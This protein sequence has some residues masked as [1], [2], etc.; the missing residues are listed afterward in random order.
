MKLNV[1]LSWSRSRSY[2]V[3]TALKQFLKEI[4]QGVAPQMSDDIESGGM[5]LPQLNDLLRKA[6][7][8]VLCITSDNWKEPWIYYEVGMVFGKSEE[9]AKVFPYIIDLNMQR[10]NLPEPLKQFTAV[11]AN[12]EGTYKLVLAINKALDYPLSDSKLKADFDANW[13]GLKKVIGDMQPA[14]DQSEPSPGQPGSPSKRPNPRL[15]VE[16][17]GM[18]SECIGS[19]Q[20]RLDSRLR[21]CIDTAIK[22]AQSGA[23]DRDRLID[24]AW[25]EIEESKERFRDKNSI[26]VGNVADFF[27]E[28]YSIDKL[29]GVVDSMEIDLLAGRDP[30]IVAD[31]LVARMKRASDDAFRHFH[32]ILSERLKECLGTGEG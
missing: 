30:D 22:A 25:R 7:F 2:A 19:H 1:F 23:Y 14:T 20:D 28:N 32:W 27:G 21:D 29:R 13:P 4:F 12:E 26:L 24:L 6:D 31:R 3:A 17:W 10:R 9:K 18:V 5:I 15:C 16:D 11:M 8:V